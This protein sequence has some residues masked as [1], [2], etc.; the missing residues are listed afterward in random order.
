[1]DNFISK[2]RSSSCCCFGRGSGIKKTINFLSLW[3]GLCLL[4]EA[5]AC[6]RKATLSDVREED[7]VFWMSCSKTLRLLYKSSIDSVSIFFFVL[8]VMARLSHAERDLKTCD[9]RL[10]LTHQHQGHPTVI[11]VFGTYHTLSLSFHIAS[12]SNAQAASTAPRGYM[13]IAMIG[14]VLDL[15]APNNPNAPPHSDTQKRNP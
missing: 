11:G 12:T 1:M 6:D 2:T 15:R 8:I 13:K 5:L 9:L 4:E 10:H 3:L 7:D 14:C